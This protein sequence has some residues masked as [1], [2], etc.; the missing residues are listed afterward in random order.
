M[1]NTYSTVPTDYEL[2]VYFF[3]T[4]VRFDVM[5]EGV[6]RARAKRYHIIM[7]SINT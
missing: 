7:E 2:S 3:L 6:R 4:R 5:R 1:V